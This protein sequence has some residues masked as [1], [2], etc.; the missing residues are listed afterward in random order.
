VP[1][2]GWQITV[3]SRSPPD[4]D[5]AIGRYD[6]G[7]PTPRRGPS[8]QD[9][10]RLAGVSAQT[11][12]RVA[13]GTDDV[14]ADTRARVRTAMD[15]LGYAPNHAARALRNGRFG[16]IGLLAHRFERTGEA[17]TTEGVVEAAQAEDFAVTL[18]DVRH[19]DAEDWEDAA[20]GLTHRAIDALIV[21]RAETATPEHLAL[22]AGMP[23]VVSD[24]RFVGHYPA[25]VADQVHGSLAATSHLLGL[26]HRTVHHLAGPV[27]SEPANVRLA[28]W[29][30]CLEDAGIRPPQVR[31]GDWTAAS[32]YAVGRELASDDAVTAVYCANDEMAMGL[33]R[34]LHEAGRRVPDDVSV[35]GFDG[36]ALAEFAYPPLTTVRQDF[37][38]IGHELV[39]LVLAQLQGGTRPRSERVVLPTELVV[40]GT[41]APPR[42]GR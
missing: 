28:S 27:D 40:R 37:H 11:V 17:L 10:A 9:V 33:M 18:V 36:I 29:R 31:R 6:P 42:A 25:V 5:V 16:T 23:V 15:Q 30:R 32:G 21:I 13:R 12:S 22:P 24:S 34:A 14:R 2:N 3:G 26:G 39:R 38:A 19:A 35:V 20:H 8:I 7:M 1:V 4:G 41:T